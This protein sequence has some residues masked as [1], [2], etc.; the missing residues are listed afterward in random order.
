MEVPWGEKIERPKKY[1]SL[2]I[3]HSSLVYLKEPIVIYPDIFNDNPLNA[4]KVVKYLLA[5]PFSFGNDFLPKATD[6]IA[7]YS[8]MV[9]GKKYLDQFYFLN[10]EPEYFKN[11]D[12]KKRRI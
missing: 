2:L 3:D 9:L 10:N 1:D 5:K 4:K 11:I 8:Q 12:I 6:Y 7:T